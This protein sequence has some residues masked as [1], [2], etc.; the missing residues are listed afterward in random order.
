MLNMKDN[1]VAEE[2]YFLLIHLG[3]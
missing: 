2:Q 1:L 3:I